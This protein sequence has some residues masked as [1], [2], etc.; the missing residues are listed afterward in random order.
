MNTK[1][2]SKSDF[3]YKLQFLL[4]FRYS[5]SECRHIL[6]DYEEWFQE[7]NR[8][9]KSDAEIC[10]HMGSPAKT[11]KKI[12]AETTSESSKLSIWMHNSF[13]QFVVLT[14]I[15]IAA[16]L[17]V[18]Y[19]CE[20]NGL[21][22]LWAAL[23]I[24][25]LYFVCAMAAAKPKAPCRLLCRENFVI[26]VLAAAALAGNAAVWNYAVRIQT[27]P[28]AVLLLTILVCILYASAVIRGGW[29]ILKHETKIYLLAFHATGLASMLL[30]CICQYHTLTAGRKQLIATSVTGSI[31]IYAE[32]LVLMLL[33]RLWKAPAKG[34]SA[35][36]LN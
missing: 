32:V 7:E 21:P 11:V 27:G 18:F 9:G 35:W 24:N 6:S 23:L 22:Y 36:T 14:C 16:D 3:L 17:S 12:T 34:D 10:S 15:R 8:S 28:S 30:Y 4:S 33:F 26:A 31:G 1:T 19:R 5:D 25:A 29:G 2:C 13:L 20:R